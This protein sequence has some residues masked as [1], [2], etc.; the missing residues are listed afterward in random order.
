[1][2]RVVTTVKAIAR[3]FVRYLPLLQNLISRELKKKYRRSI[4]GYLWCVLNPLMVMVIMYLVFS[5]MFR[6]SIEN[7]PVYLFAGRMMFSFITDSTNSVSRAFIANGAL[8][9]KTRIPY[10]IFPLSNFCGAVVNFLFSLI[11]FV[12]VLLFTR[13]PVSIHVL[14]FPFVFVQMAMFSLGLGLF[15]AQANT[16]VRDVGY[17]YSVLTTAWMYLTPLFY[18]IESLPETLR[19]VISSVNPA[20][21]YV[22]QSRMIFLYHQWPEGTI[23]SLG[24][25]FGAVFLLIGLYSYARS[26]DKLIL[27][28]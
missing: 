10:Y 5:N 27:Y 3:N 17:L 14:A 21:M 12:I 26:K 22:Q 9:R 15:L 2:K 25:L 7:F 11:A 16:F 24:T 28:I 19:N 4:L 18:P 13:T 1:M 20:Y 6:N 23:V 8:M